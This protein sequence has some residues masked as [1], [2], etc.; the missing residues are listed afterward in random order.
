MTW[1]WLVT[2]ASI[3]GVVLNVKRKKAC[4]IVWACSNFVWM[5]IDYQ[6]GLY[7]QAALFLIYFLLAIWGLWEWRKKS[8]DKAVRR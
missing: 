1:T 8:G 5:I 7:S 2:L 3:I 6:N 4:F